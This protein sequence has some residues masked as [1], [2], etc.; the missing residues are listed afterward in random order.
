MGAITA[1]YDMPAWERL[2][3]RYLLIPAV[4]SAFEA[5]ATRFAWMDSRPDWGPGRI[6]PFN[7]VKFFN[8]HLPDDGTIGNSDIMPLWDFNA[9]VADTTRQYSLHWDGLLSD[10]HDTVVAGAIGDGMDYQGYT[11]VKRRL[12]AIIDFI[13]LQKPPPSPFSP[14]RAAD[15]PY[16]VDDAEKH[17]N[18]I[19]EKL[20]PSMERARAASDALEAVIPEDIWTLPTYADSGSRKTIL[21]SMTGAASL[22]HRERRNFT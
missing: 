10:L 6:D 15:D 14:A 12:D 3:Y 22:A 8:L 21:I 11:V 18:F 1:I 16:H 17:A 9:V 7:P 13:R 20:V 4:G 19:H 5:Q 2:L